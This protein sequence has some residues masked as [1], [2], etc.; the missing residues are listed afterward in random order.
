MRLHFLSA[1]I[2]TSLSF[3]QNVCKINFELARRVNNTA[4]QYD[5]V[6]VLIKGDMT[7]IKEAVT[8]I[9]GKF[10][11]SAGDI[12]SVNIRLKDIR[13]LALQ[14]F[15]KRMEFTNHRFLLMSD[16]MRIKVNVDAVQTGQAPLP[17]AYDG[18]GVVVGIIDSGTDFNNPDFKD[19]NGKSR[20]KFLWDQ[21]KPLDVNTPQPYN[22]GQEWDNTA[23]DL[24]QCTH[25]DLVHSGHG[26]NSS[27]RAAGNGSSTPGNKYRGVAPNA[28]LIVVAFNFSNPSGNCMPEAVDY[29]YSKAQAMGK[30][31]VINISIGDYYG[32]H[33]GTDLQAQMMNNLL[34]AANGR[35]MT[36]SAGNNGGKRFHLGYTA[37]NAD[38]NFTWF[39]GNNAYWGGATYIA[40]YGD[41]AN[42]KNISFSI[43]A[44]KVTPTYEFRGA[45]NFSKIAQHIG[46][47]LYDTIRNG[48]NRLAIVQ[49]YGDLNNG[50]YSMEFLISPDSTAYNWRLSVTGSGKFDVWSPDP[51]RAEGTD[52]EYANLPTPTA[53]PNIA[54]YKSPD[55]LQT[56]CSSFQ[57]VDNIITVGNFNN[58]RTYIGYDNNLQMPYPGIKPGHIDIGSSIGPTRDGRIK[59]D[60]AAPG[61]L[62]MTSGVV[63]TM[64]G[65]Q[66]TAPQ[67][68]DQTGINVR[69]GGTSAS[70]P[71]VAGVAA[72]YLQK[73]PTATAAQ[74]KNAIHACPTIDSITG[75]NLPNSIWGY[76][77]VN[78]FTTLAGCVTGVPLL[79][80]NVLFGIY[81]N[82]F[83]SETTISFDLTNYRYRSAQIKIN[84]VVGKIICEINI[85]D[86]NSLFTLNKEQLPNGS[87]ICNL[88]IDGKIIKSQKLI[89]VE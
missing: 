51:S 26:T 73:N 5:Y 22:Y 79:A 32:S 69:A 27:G 83:N 60:I 10:I 53:F 15:V 44:D 55:S 64:Q 3:G 38:T 29:I 84:D 33:D 2:I 8:E 46:L 16:S 52:M 65:W 24:G 85:G 80:N 86:K 1:I 21:N 19:T 62:T 63:S 87:Y 42:F 36:A 20:I 70:A 37:S 48:N 57:C 34:T 39:K 17:Q 23:I 25:T 6:S 81:P 66:T 72:L 67:N 88:V 31:C 49:S 7:L 76:G 12:A 45:T 43:G 78:A 58:K 74:V 56:I 50:V 35:A 82:P 89:A 54:N 71:V 11:C 61:A 41:T 28:D 30:P 40:M 9:G 77:K 13:V 47:N 18:T 14:P 59:P 75:S 4:A 68:L